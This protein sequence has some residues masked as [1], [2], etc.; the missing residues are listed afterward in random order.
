M[1]K[2]IAVALV[3]AVMLFASVVVAQPENSSWPMIK[4]NPQA[5]G[6][7]RGSATTGLT[8]YLKWVT[9]IPYN[10]PQNYNGSGDGCAVV[11]SDSNIY[12]TT[13]RRDPAL[14]G[15]SDGV[16]KLD[17]D[18]NI[19]WSRGLDRP[20]RMANIVLGNER[21]YVCG[22][23]L[24]GDTIWAIDKA[25]GNV[26][27]TL[28]GA[29]LANLGFETP[30]MDSTGALYVLD[31]DRAGG[32]VHNQN[33]IKVTDLGVS[34]MVSWVRAYNEGAAVGKDWARHAISVAINDVDIDP[35]TAGVQCRTKTGNP[36]VYTLCHRWNNWIGIDAATGVVNWTIRFSNPAVSDYDYWP[37]MC[38]DE[39]GY[40]YT[41][42]GRLD[43]PGTAAADLTHF[44]VKIDPSV[45]EILWTYWPLNAAGTPTPY[46]GWKLS[47]PTVADGRVYI[48]GTANS[49]LSALDAATGTR[50]WHSSKGNTSM[51]ET[52]ALPSI[53]PDG[54]L[55]AI[56]YI[57]NT[58]RKLAKF[59]ASTGEL[60]W[61]KGISRDNTEYGY[62]LYLLDGQL[63]WNNDGTLILRGYTDNTGG[64]GTKPA[65]VMAFQPEPT[66]VTILSPFELVEPIE[67]EIPFHLA[68]GAS[69]GSMPYTWDLA[70]GTLPDGVWISADG[71]LK[72]APDDGTAG[73]YTFTVRVTDDNSNTDTKQYTLEVVNGDLRLGP[74]APLGAVGTPYGGGLWIIGG[75]K[76]PVVGGHYD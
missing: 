48:M 60:V 30:T 74:G 41:K 2:Y 39:S 18:G 1:S 15:F 35:G 21:V 9:D 27:W 38:V 34:G 62:W 52:G 58:G 40:V 36:E 47:S 3:L 7:Y 49:G 66:T 44:M 55:Y 45:P 72:G 13:S 69:G 59:N 63:C 28:R 4:G 50:V 26:L 29:P 22:G 11:D 10:S 46:Q 24:N 6:Q 31:Y 14:V 37:G 67:E 43:H 17:Q 20:P 70:S 12:F 25:T 19:L 51:A 32:V 61:E 71:N 42:G 57:G 73:A 23:E 16:W 76:P 54:N 56:I 33:V 65:T 64:P 5:T 68:F 75:T 53:G 8:P